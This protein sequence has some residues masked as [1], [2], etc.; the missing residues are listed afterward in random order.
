MNE[1]SPS[2]TPIVIIGAG[3]H[4]KVVIELIAASPSNR[5][6]GLTDADNS[7]RQVAGVDVLGGDDIL[8]NLRNTGV[9]HAFVALGDNTRRHLVATRVRALGFTLVNAISSAAI[10]SP[11]A[12]LGCGVAV[13]A[14]VVINA[15]STIGDFAII[16][17]GAV[18]DHDADLGEACHVG[19]G[20]ALAGSVTLGPRAFL[21]VGASV[22]PGVLI[23]ETT[24]VG[25]GACVTVDLP[26]GVLAVG[27]PAR[28]VR[29]LNQTTEVS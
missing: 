9:T 7:A 28:V 8:P 21:G 11:S 26:A 24:M 29:T 6:V 5:V 4:A 14:G 15:G 3:G 10:I 17:S 18:V 25:A 19:P 16:N 23:G 1:I 2:P 27:V 12:R 20:C 13:M 22:A